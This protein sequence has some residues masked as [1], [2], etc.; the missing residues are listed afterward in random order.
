MAVASRKLFLRSTSV[1]GLRSAAQLSDALAERQ[2]S[3]GASA[4]RSVVMDGGKRYWR[5]AHIGTVMLGNCHRRWADDVKQHEANPS[6]SGALQQPAAGL[7]HGVSSWPMAKQMCRHAAG[8]NC[9]G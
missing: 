5:H 8:A 6:Y 2:V 4:G 7:K 1:Q 9:S 3:A